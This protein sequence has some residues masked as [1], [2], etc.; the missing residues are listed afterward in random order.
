MKSDTTKSFNTLINHI[1]EVEDILFA[2]G[3]DFQRKDNDEIYLNYRGIWNNYEMSFKWIKN[4]DLVRINNNLSI[5]VPKNMIP[6]IQS[7]ISMV[8][9]GLTLGY[10]G[11]S[12][13]KNCIYFRHNILLRGGL[14]FCTEQVEEFFDLMVSECDKYY[15]A[16]QIYIQKINNPSFAL[17]TALL[18]TIGEA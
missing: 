9:E 10:F 8:N 15:P 4:Y 17:K 2:Y 12:S 11:Y 7:M 6:G 18:E 13:N 1:D 14:N 16:Y 3:L 5:S